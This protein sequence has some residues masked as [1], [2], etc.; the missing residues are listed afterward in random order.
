VTTRQE[1][2]A[3]EKREIEYGG[4]KKKFARVEE[5]TKGRT[6]VVQKREESAT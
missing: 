5:E 4:N 3:K 6:R 2:R 1:D